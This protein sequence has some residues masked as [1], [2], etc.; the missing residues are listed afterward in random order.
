MDRSD[1]IFLQNFG[2]SPPE[3]SIDFGKSSRNIFLAFFSSSKA[4][5]IE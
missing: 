3:G 2:A 4:L 1:T 5:D